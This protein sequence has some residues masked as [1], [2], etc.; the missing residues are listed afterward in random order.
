MRATL[1]V[2]VPVCN[3]QAI[4][5]SLIAE[6]LDVLP[7][8]APRFELVVVDNGSVDATGEVIQE[9]TGHYPQVNT[10]FLP[11][12]QGMAQAV[13]AGLERT[14]GDLVMVCADP[15]AV[16]LQDINR[17]YQAAMTH[18]VVTGRLGSRAIA[19]WIP[20][21]PG[22]A[23]SMERAGLMIVRRQLISSWQWGIGSEDLLSFLVRQGQKLFEVDVRGRQP[24]VRVDAMVDKLNASLANNKSE[25][26]PAAKQN[27]PRPKHT[28]YLARLRDLALGE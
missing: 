1:S 2:I 22:A 3:A 7:E 25:A 18:D 26:Q 13:R 4:V 27:V 9:I 5:G 12:Q 6:L 24:M 14:N 19:G 17:L 15:A 20:R 8:I 16:N 28:G 21:L 23:P 10:A 11:T